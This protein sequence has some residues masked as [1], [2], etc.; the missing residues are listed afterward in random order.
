[1]ASRG[2]PWKTDTAEIISPLARDECVARLRFRIDRPWMIVGLRPVLGRVDQISMRLRKRI[3]YGNSMQT[4]LRAS[5]HDHQ[6]GTRIDCRL[7]ISRFFAWF[8]GIWFAGV[9]GIGGLML[10]I[11]TYQYV[12]GSRSPAPNA[13]L[14]YVVIPGMVILGVAVDRF[15]RF[16]ARGEKGFLLRFVCEAVNG[17]IEA[18]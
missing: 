1:M 2:L 5:L 17:R 7:G 16:L 8:Y 4:I 15:G 18:S 14:V 13:W 10:V 3:W 11:V 12:A 9:A 6:G